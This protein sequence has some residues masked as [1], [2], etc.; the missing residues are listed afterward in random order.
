MIADCSS[1][2]VLKSLILKGIFIGLLLSGC[3]VAPTAP[4]ADLQFAIVGKFGIKQ[5]DTG[6][7]ANF[8]WQQF[9]RGYDIEVWGPLGQGRTLLQGNGQRMMVQR[10]GQIKAQ[11]SPEE[12]MQANLGW[13]VPIHVLPA[14]IRGEPDSE[15][16][17]DAAVYDD[18]GRFTAF[19]Q[20]GWQVNLSQYTARQAFATPARIVARR[21]VKKVTVIVR[22]YAQ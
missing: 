13:S 6:Y 8:S 9:E 2:T 16:G 3:A 11:G 20:A 22:K 17:F 21:G 7:S 12:V 14:W 19:A 5:A 10:G 18:Q 15:L 4:S 1:N